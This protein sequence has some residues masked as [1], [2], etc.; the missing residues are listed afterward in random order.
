V[1][2]A[3][4]RRFIARWLWLASALA[5]TVTIDAAAADS[6]HSQIERGRY[7][8]Q[9]GDCAACH[10]AEGG[11]AFAGGRAIPT[12]FGTIFSTNITPDQ[13]TGIG[14][15]TASDFYRAMHSGIG[16]DGK[17]LYPA[18]PYPWY[19]KL[20]REDVD[21]IKAFLDTLAPVRE[22]NKSSE[23]PFPL[24]VRQ[25]VAGWNMLYFDE[26]GFKPDPNKSA[27]WN[28]GAYL[29][30]GLGHCGACHT[31]KTFAGGPKKDQ[32]FAGG[33]G[34]NW[35][36]SNLTGDKT[37]GLGAWSV[38]DI[39]EYLKTGSNK[40]AAAGGPMAEV[41][42]HSTQHLREADLRAM[43]VY[44]KDLP[45]QGG[46]SGEPEAADKDRFAR[47]EALYTDQCA[48]CHMQKGE[49]QPGVFPPLKGNAVVQSRDPETMVH[50]ILS[51][52]QIAATKD[53]PTGLKMPAFDWKLSDQD[54]ADLTTYLRQ[55]WGNHAAPVSDS[56][57]GSIRHDIAEASVK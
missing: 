8:A 23:L 20:S 13:T 38:D 19:T 21:A 28:R 53:K 29:I 42:M 43:A 7:L 26:G 49:G 1:S 37:V 18:F 2:A 50:M 33:Y 6:S 17:H 12:P 56:K 41:V 40:L 55:A 10:T 31:A 47:G 22:E 4:H 44:L 25:S 39:V 57:V 14:Q 35:F 24:S 3:R 48:G 52:I 54:I 51:G 46:Q 9:A 36:A 5:C 34:E 11:K 45:A 32:R 15:W 30:E 16:R 27:E